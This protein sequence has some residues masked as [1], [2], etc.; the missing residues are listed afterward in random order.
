MSESIGHKISHTHARPH[1]GHDATFVAL[2]LLALV[3]RTTVPGE[4]FGSLTDLM[5]AQRDL[6][7]GTAISF[8]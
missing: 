1:A 7:A 2:L 8:A 4:I 3:Y 5:P 6:S